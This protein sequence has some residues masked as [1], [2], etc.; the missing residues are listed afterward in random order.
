MR[1]SSVQEA[2]GD[3]GS[4]GSDDDKV[5]ED[6]EDSSTSKVGLGRVQTK[7]VVDDVEDSSTGKDETSGVRVSDG[8]GEIRIGNLLQGQD[9]KSGETSVCVCRTIKMTTCR[10]RKLTS[11]VV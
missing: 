3:F 1:S 11:W 4:Q 8:T 5:V 9:E 6:V 7:K 2:S 10:S